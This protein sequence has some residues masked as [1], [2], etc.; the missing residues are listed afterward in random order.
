VRELKARKAK[1]EVVQINGRIVWFKTFK[2]FYGIFD[3]E[4]KLQYPEVVAKMTEIMQR[5]PDLI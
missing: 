3:I 5:P 2:K 1:R 4:N